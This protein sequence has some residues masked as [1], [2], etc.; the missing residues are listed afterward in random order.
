M[1]KSF[2]AAFLLY[3]LGT[4]VVYFAQQYLYTRSQAKHPA[5]EG[6]ETLVT[7]GKG[8]GRFAEGMVK[9]M[10]AKGGE[11]RQ[12]EGESKKS[13]AERETEA[14]GRKAA[15]PEG[16]TPGKRGGR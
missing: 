10:S 12:G 6:T 16:K 3:W 5:A 7:D 2:P 8:K 1:F 14:K 13:L 9:M 4:N 11:S 15:K